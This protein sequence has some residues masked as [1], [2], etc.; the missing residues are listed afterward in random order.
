MWVCVPLVEYYC[1]SE[2]VWVGG[3]VSGC[4]CECV[5]VYVGLPVGGRV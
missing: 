3:W 1:Y 2:W 4:M 5:C